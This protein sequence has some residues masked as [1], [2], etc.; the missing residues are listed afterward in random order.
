MT[1][2]FNG[3]E[4]ADASAVV[5]RRRA[6]QLA[7]A[8]SLSAAAL[9]TA[10]ASTASAGIEVPSNPTALDDADRALVGYAVSLELACVQLYTS[11]VASNK[12]TGDAQAVVKTLADHHSVHRQACAALAGAANPNVANATVVAEFTAKFAGGD[13][14][15]AWQL[16]NRMVASHLYLIGAVKATKGSETLASIMNADCAQAAVLGSLSGNESL[17]EVENV[18][19]VFDPA[20]YSVV[21]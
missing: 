6:F 9:A 5:S 19:G 12:L 3:S 16:E 1:D 10:L 11:M 20:K 14:T 2:H 21:K 13:L 4:L 8:A 17:V 7:G 18:A 15:A